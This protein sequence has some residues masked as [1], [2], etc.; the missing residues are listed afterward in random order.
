MTIPDAALGLLTRSDFYPVLR[1][2]RLGVRLRLPTPDRL[3]DH[4]IGGVVRRVAQ[5][6]TFTPFASAQACSARCVFCSETLVHRDARVLSA[7]LRPAGDYHAGLRRALH[8][9]RGLPI[10]ISLS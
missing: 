9:L 6:V 10:G 3:R 8:E 5:P 1:D 7:S 2:A 4:R